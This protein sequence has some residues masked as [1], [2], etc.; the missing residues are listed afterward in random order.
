MQVVIIA[1]GLG[2][3]LGSLTANQPKSLIP[4][5]FEHFPPEAKFAHSLCYHVFFTVLA[6]E[7]EKRSKR[8]S[9]KAGQKYPLS[10]S[11]DMGFLSTK[12]N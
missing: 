12:N 3:R 5:D 8:T 7:H 10:Y 4:I 6:I 9:A 2:T 1:G 11:N